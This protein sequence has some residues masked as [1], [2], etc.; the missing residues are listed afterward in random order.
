MVIE[1][2]R[3]A[4]KTAL[5]VVGCARA[6]FVDRN[7]LSPPIARSCEGEDSDTLFVVADVWVLVTVYEELVQKTAE[8]S[9][10][11]RTC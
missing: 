4:S 6:M 11:D 8:V 3:V 10:C 7:L 5:V 9:V 1:T 2:L